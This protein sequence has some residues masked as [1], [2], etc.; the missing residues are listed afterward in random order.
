LAE[1]KNKPVEYVPPVPWNT[2]VEVFVVKGE[3]IR[4]KRMTF[5]E[6]MSL[7][8]VPGWKYQAYEPGYCSLKP[9]E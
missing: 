8:R 5:R 2:E 7:K 9:T 4:M 3:R 1:R 6:W